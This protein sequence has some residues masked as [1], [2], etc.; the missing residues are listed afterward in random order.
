MRV[1]MAILSISTHAR[2][3]RSFV[4]KPGTFGFESL[5]GGGDGWSIFAAFALV[6]LAVGG[7]DEFGGRPPCH[8]PDTSAKREAGKK[9]SRLRIYRPGHASRKVWSTGLHFD[10]I[11]Q[12]HRS[13]HEFTDSQVLSMLDISSEDTGLKPFKTPGVLDGNDSV[14]ARS[15][16]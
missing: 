1:S 4:S 14:R 16:A 7:F 8:P 11:G 9:Q 13:A 6:Q 12:V 10:W 3:A 5:N 2:S 15:Y